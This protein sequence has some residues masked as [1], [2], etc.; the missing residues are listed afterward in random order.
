MSNIKIFLLSH[1]FL[2]P[3]PR[4]TRSH[5][6]FSL[7]CSDAEKALMAVSVLANVHTGEVL[8]SVID[9]LPHASSAQEFRIILVAIIAVNSAKQAVEEIGL[10]LVG[11]VIGS[12][13]ILN[14]FAAGLLG[15]SA[16]MGR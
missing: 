4:A 9:V 5:C 6:C 16:V 12:T 7:S 10:A 2:Q 1:F 13:V 3:E 15:S 11:L 14:S 8:Q